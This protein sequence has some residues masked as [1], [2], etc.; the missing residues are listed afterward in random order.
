MRGVGSLPDGK[1]TAMKE[2]SPFSE[3]TY[4]EIKHAILKERVRMLHLESSGTR[5]PSFTKSECLG[6]QIH[7]VYGLVLN[8]KSQ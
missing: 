6:V 8:T 2:K 5:W 4:A 1:T 7:K 3:E